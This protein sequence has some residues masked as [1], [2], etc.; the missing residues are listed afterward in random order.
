MQV[1]TP[2]RRSLILPAML[3]LVTVPGSLT[4]AA[5]DLRLT[6]RPP[7]AGVRSHAPIPVEVMLECRSSQLIEG[8]LRLTFLD[9]DHVIGHYRSGELALTAGEKR[10]RMLLPPLKITTEVSLLTTR[11]RFTGPRI[12]IDLG[13]H[14]FRAPLYWKRS[15]VIGI[16]QPETL[17][18]PDAWVDLAPSLSLEKYAPDRIVAQGLTTVHS[19]LVPNELPRSGVGYTAYDLL[20]LMG[21]G[22]AELDGEQLEAI[23][24]W[25]EAGGSLCLWPSAP[26]KPEHV[27]FLNRLAGDEIAFTTDGA[28][29]L[30]TD[31]DMPD[32]G[33]RL[34]RH[35]LGRAVLILRPLDPENDVRSREW[36]RAVAFLWKLRADQTAALTSAVRSARLPEHWGELRADQTAGLTTQNTWRFSVE[37]QEYSSA[38]EPRPLRPLALDDQK[39]LQDLLL[40]SQITGMP[41]HV[42]ISLL[43]VFLLLVAPG[44]YFLLGYLKARRYTW[45]LFLVISLGFTWFTVNLAGDYMSATDFSSRLIFVDWTG[46]ERPARV[47]EYEMVFTATQ[48]T[49]EERQNDALRAPVPPVSAGPQ[50]ARRSGRWAGMERYMEEDLPEWFG[51][52]LPPPVYRGFMPAVFVVEQHMP[53]WTPR[54]S[55]RTQFAPDGP[56]PPVDWSKFTPEDFHTEQGRA[57]F[58]ATVRQVS[59]EATVIMIG[60][61]TDDF[62]FPPEDDLSESAARFRD[63][64]GLVR[65]MSVRPAEGLFQILSQLSPTGHSNGEDLTLLDPSDP[66]QRL[67]LIIVR[68]RDDYFVHRRLY[69]ER[70]TEP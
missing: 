25:V 40:P 8:E 69:T 48:K 20:L 36:R 58:A 63:I 27:R 24:D 55:R 9:G 6:I 35:G 47:S 34:D 5:D 54:M 28:G 26:L 30:M 29:R 1:A 60:E 68:E 15:F 31:T 3:L 13:E 41:K 38:V 43:V 45:L 7:S 18:S 33:L 16:L 56:A 23:A 46:G 14:E 57:A 21:E 17:L 10:F 37:E 65:Q 52:D 64:V 42:V 67:V 51:S 39:R 12:D 19:R 2:S 61:T 70:S 62:G 32:S 11:A 50:Y 44:D 22:F 66:A 49:L 4:R 53:K 59:P